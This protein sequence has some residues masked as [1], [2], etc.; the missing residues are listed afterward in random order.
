MKA[1]GAH[2]SV[3]A[4]CRRCELP[5]CD[6]R[7]I[8][9]R[10]NWRATE[11]HSPPPPPPSPPLRPPRQPLAPQVVRRLTVVRHF[12]AKRQRAMPPRP[13]FSNATATVFTCLARR[14][15]LC[16]ARPVDE[17]RLRTCEQK[18][19]RRRHFRHFRKRAMPIRPLFSNASATVFTCLARRGRLCF[20]R[21]VDEVRLR[22]CEQKTQRRRHFRHFRKRAMPIRPLFSNATAT[23]FTCMAR[24]A[25]L[26]F[27]RPARGPPE[28]V[29]AKTPSGAVTSVTSAKEQCPQTLCCTS[30]SQHGRS[31]IAGHFVALSKK[32]SRRTPSSLSTSSLFKKGPRR[33]SNAPKPS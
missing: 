20:A 33:T 2:A 14:G 22:T 15:R 7:Q 28:D 32:G 8:R 24:R 21:P 6:T 11:C 1:T 12:H 27:A 10:R 30:K 25:R 26:C 16:F 4:S 5:S 9:Y 23:V 18:T 31:G 13:L 29:R 17:V 19:Q 3:D